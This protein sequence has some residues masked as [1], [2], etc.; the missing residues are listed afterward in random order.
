MKKLK[1]K[2]IIVLSGLFIIFMAGL[3][4][5]YLIKGDSSRW[6]VA[7]GGIVVSALPLLLL[8]MQNNPFNIPIIL[9][10]Y[11]FIFCTIFL[12]SIASFYLHFKWWDSTIHFLKGALVGFI[13]I[14]LYQRFIPH[15][16]RKDVSRW[17]IFL[18]VLSLAVSSSV[19]WEIYEFIGDQTFTHTMQ[20]GGNTDTMIDL[21]CGTAGGQLV[22]VYSIIKK[23]Q[24]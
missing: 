9:A 18:F 3:L 4:V 2:V 17:I 14:A 7:I 16:V 6:Q 5:Y 1:R 13:G 22:A 11:L 19:L 24:V 23:S 15:K 8:L 10:Y 12:G 21:L 20:R